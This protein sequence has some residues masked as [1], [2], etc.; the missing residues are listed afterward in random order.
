MLSEQAGWYSRQI[1][2]VLAF[3][4]APIDCDVFCH[5]PSGF[6]IEGNNRDEYVIQLV[7][8]LYGTKQAAANWF[9]MLKAGLVKEGF[10]QSKIDPC[11]FLRQ[12]AII[13]TY[14]DDCLIFMKEKDKIQELLNNLQKTFILTDEGEYVK[15]YLG[16]K[17]EKAKDGTITMSQPALINRILIMLSLDGD[18]VKMHDTPVNKILIRN[19]DEDPRKYDWN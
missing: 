13:I 16:L 10:H 2:Y 14:V 8:N 4:Q 3:S 19:D 15:A 18:N 7:K 17:V 9:E 12:D 6:H 11:L 5:L 1:D